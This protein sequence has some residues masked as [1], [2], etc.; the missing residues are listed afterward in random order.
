MELEALCFGVMRLSACQRFAS[1]HDKRYIWH[2]GRFISDWLAILLILLPSLF[3]NGN[4]TEGEIFKMINLLK[5]KCFI[6]KEN[7]VFLEAT[8]E[9]VY[10]CPVCYS[11]L[12]ADYLIDF[13]EIFMW[14]LMPQYSCF[15][16]SLYS[17]DFSFLPSVLWRC[18]LGGRKGIWPVKNWVVGCW[19]G[20]LS[21]A[22]CRLA[23]GPADATATH[24]LLLH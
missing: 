24:C 22:R 21:G 1:Y 20:C 8:V 18:W 15:S 6:R 4:C 16:V 13:I 14:V 7:S 19:R 12:C 10:H 5:L 23:Y 11:V 2:P 9:I 3:K 17:V